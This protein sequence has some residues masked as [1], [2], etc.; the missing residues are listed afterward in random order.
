MTTKTH[1]NLVVFGVPLL[2]I[3]TVILITKSQM[4]ATNTSALSIGI[5]LDLL[6]TIPIVYFILIKKKNI[7]KTTVVPFFILGMVIASYIIPQEHQ[8]TLNWA[9]NWI[10]PFVELSVGL[11]VFYKFRQTIKRYKANAKQELDFFSALKETCSEIAPGKIAIFL[12]MELAVLYYGFISWKKRI[13]AENEFTYH[14]NSGTISLLAALIVIIG[15][16]TYVLHILLLKWSA[17]AAWIA[18]ILSVYSSIQIFGFLKSITKRPVTI[19]G[20]ILHLRY[21]ILSET[22]IN[23]SSIAS[24][25]MTNKEI[26]FDTKT[27]KLSPLGELESHN[28]LITLKQENIFSGLYGM[29]KTYKTIAFF[30]DD[31]EK[32]TSL[33]KEKLKS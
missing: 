32:F 26:E 20:D 16:E 21:G 2:L 15:V 24:I 18:S 14:K 23:I 33:I 12:T 7:P 27:I 5:T 10:F 8:S 19:E 13:L 3:L 29:K 6:F 28:M 31:K 30:I 22:T 11:F 4:F 9:K 25:E 17:I 1:S